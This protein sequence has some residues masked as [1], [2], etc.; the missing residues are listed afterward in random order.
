MENKELKEGMLPE[1]E[2]KEVAGG[3][4]GLETGNNGNGG[5]I[6]FSAKPDTQEKK[7]REI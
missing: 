1:E 7:A 5:N 3:K 4:N 2:L 6:I